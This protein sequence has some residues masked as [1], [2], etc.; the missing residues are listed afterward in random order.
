[1]SNLE[2]RGAA[3]NSWLLCYGN[4]RVPLARVVPDATQPLMWQN[5]LTSGNLSDIVN[6]ARAKD[7]AA[8]VAERGPPQRNRRLLHWKQEPSKTLSGAPPIAGNEPPLAQAAE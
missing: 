6:L 5:A 7:A 1:M 4:A 8:A 2:Q 3:F